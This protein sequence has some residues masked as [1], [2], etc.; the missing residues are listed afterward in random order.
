MARFRFFL[1]T[2]K[3]K[4]E[5]PIFLS[6]TYS[7]NR[8]KVKTKQK[9]NPKAWN[10]SS[11][12]VRKN[13]TEY[14]EVQNLLNKIELKAKKII[15]EFVEKGQ[16]I[17]APK[18]LKKIVENKLF[19]QNDDEVKTSFWEFFED[20]I[21]KLKHKKNAITG[22]PISKGTIESYNQT[23]VT[24][25]KFEKDTGSILSFITLSNKTYDDIILYLEEGLNFAPNT[26]GKHIKNFKSVINSAK[27]KKQITISDDYNEKYWSV[28]KQ[29]RSAD[30]IVFLTEDELDEL[31]KLD[32]SKNKTLEVSRDIFLIG[33]WTAL[34]IIDIVK[35]TKEHINEERGVIHFQ[36]QKTNRQVSIPIHPVVIEIL[37]KYDNVAPKLAEPTVNENIKLACKKIKSLHK[38]VD[39]KE[40][41]GNKQEMVEYKRY[42]K[43][44]THTGRRSFASN[45]YKRHI[46]I[47][48]IMAITG[49]KKEADFF[50]YIGVTNDEHAQGLSAK[51]KEWY[52]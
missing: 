48:Q 8:A 44:T 16:S 51:F 6:I 1:L 28:I 4:K 47:Q 10:K 25:Q 45:M 27:S 32:L 35:L 5:V 31:W 15:N 49:H 43:V 26:V 40:I 20:F 34:R 3:N 42:E 14:T 9:I 30:E 13:W 23:F 22:R 24:F 19:A 38:K 21:E 29:V 36:P 52:K 17:P 41:K 39:R 33:A 18:E 46:P 50:R 11:S 2:P 12:S 37:E 7:G